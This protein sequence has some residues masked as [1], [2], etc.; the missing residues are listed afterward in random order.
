MLFFVGLALILVYYI[1]HNTDSIG[2][3]ISTI[4]SILTP[5]Y[6]GIVLAYLMCPIYNWTVKRVYHKLDGRL[7]RS[8]SGYRI[9]RVTGTVVSLL[10]MILIVVGFIV[11]I[12]PNL[13][14]SIITI[15]ASI[16]PAVN[17]LNDWAVVHIQENSELVDLLQNNLESWTDKLLEWIQQKLQPA[18][19][20]VLSGVS[21]GIVGTFRGVFN[22]FVALIICIY[23]LNSKELFQAQAK[24]LILAFFKPRWAEEFFQLGRIC[25]R[26]FGGF[27]NGKIIDSF[28]I[29]V[30]CFLIMELM[31]LP[32]AVLVSVIVGVTNI[33]P[34]FG[35]F[36]GMVPS[37]LLL[38]MVEPLAALK[39]IIMILIL[40]QVDGNIIGPKILGDTTGL[41]SFWVMFAI[42]VGGGLFGLAG[43]VLGVPVFA[44]FYVYLARI[45]NRLLAHKGM[46]TDTAVYEDFG[47]YNINKEDIFGKER[48]EKNNRETA[49][50]AA[51]GKETLG[52]GES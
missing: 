37:A 21:V 7:P 34:F 14:D 41:A 52:E 1:I 43:M 42:I 33:I 48:F 30:L 51:V 6:G 11:L 3:G 47:K 46:E 26:T 9:A 16:R 38:L 15:V 36:I 18:T 22:A 17:Q 10:V 50:A 5:F 31:G 25:N 29:G 39:F 8:Q 44:I 23:I 28:I 49:A 2:H 40:Q 35:P 13:V 12:I 32:M 24:K 4:N 20:M 27:I 19:E 45:V